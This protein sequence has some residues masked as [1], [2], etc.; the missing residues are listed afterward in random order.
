MLLLQTTPSQ[1]PILMIKKK[2][3]LGPGRWLVDKS[4]SIRTRVQIPSTHVKVG[5]VG[6][7]LAIWILERQTRHTLEQACYLA[8]IAR[9]PGSGR[10]L[11]KNKKF[12]VWL[13]TLDTLSLHTCMYTTPWGKRRESHSFLTNKRDPCEKQNIVKI[14]QNLAGS[15]NSKFDLFHCPQRH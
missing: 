3:K 9:S 10:D 8:R 14:E 4:T 13:L 2:K 15:R 11:T 6:W 12:R 1:L 5:Q 7:T